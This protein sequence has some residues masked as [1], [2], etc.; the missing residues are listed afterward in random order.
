MYVRLFYKNSGDWQLTI[1]DLRSTNDL[2][3]LGDTSLPLP[4]SVCA[5]HPVHRIHR[6]DRIMRTHYGKDENIS[7]LFGFSP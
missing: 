2:D 3:G 4:C 5:Q 1:D 6:M 7:P